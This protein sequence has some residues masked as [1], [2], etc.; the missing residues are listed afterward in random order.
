MG[1]KNFFP[2]ILMILIIT[3]SLAS[4]IIVAA[5]EP[6]GTVVVEKK[7]ITVTIP[8]GGHYAVF[9]YPDKGVFMETPIAKPHLP[10][11]AYEALSKV[12]DWIKPILERQFYELMR[13]DLVAS[14]N[15][16]VSASDFNGDG[17]VDLAVGGSNG[18]ISFYVNV[19]SGLEA[20]FKPYDRI[21]VSNKTNVAPVL[22]DMDGD[23]LVDIVVGLGDGSVVFY[24]NTGTIDSPVWSIDFN[25]FEGVAVGGYA[26]PF[27][28]DADGDGDL[29]LAVGSSEGL[30]YCFINNG[31]PASPS[32]I[33]DPQYFPAWIEDWWDGRGPH[34]E[35]VWVGNYS[36]PALATIGGTT[37]LFIGTNGSSIHVFKATGL[38]DGYPTWSNIGVLPDIELPGARPYLVDL[39]GDGLLDL[40]IGCSDGRVYLVLNKGSPD[41]MLFKVWESGAEEMLLA[42]WFWGPAYYPAIESLT[43]VETTMK[44]VDYYAEIILNTSEPYVDEVAYT[45]A[46]DRPSNLRMLADKDAGYLY[47]LNAESIYDMASKVPYAEISEKEDYST[48]K[49]KT[50]SGWLETP[51]EVYYKY[52]VM[53]N[54]YIIAP[55][56][57]P[58]TYNGCFYRT[59]LPYD[60]TYNVSLFERVSNASTLYEAAYLVDYWLRADIQSWWH[61]GPK[62]R[63]WYNI[64]F[65]LTDPNAGIWC[66]E[67][68]IIYEVAARAM[69]IPTIN[70][71]DIAEDHQFNNFWYNDSWHH[72]DASS[73]SSGVNGTW[74]NYFDPPRGYHDSWFQGTYPMEWEEDGMYDV[75]W[76]SKVPYNPPDKL[77]NLHF[78]VTDLNGKP[79]DGARVEVWSHWTIESGYDTAPYI[80]GF[81]F[82]DMNGECTLPNVGLSRTNNFTIIVTSR[83]GSTMFEAHIEEAGDYYFNVTI[84]GELPPV[85]GPV[86]VVE[87][88]EVSSKYISLNVSV[89]GGEQN[90][91]SWI[92][93]LYAYFDYKYYYVLSGGV[94]AD[95]YVLTGS[96]FTEFLS[97]KPFEA[98]A[99]FED[100]DSASVKFIPV[101]S[102]PLVIVVSNRDSVTTTITV[103]ISV[104]LL[105]DVE[106]PTTIITSPVSG[107]VF[108]T[109][110]VTV[111]FTSSSPD[112]AYFEVSIDGGEFFKAYPP[113]VLEDLSDGIHEVEVRGVDVSGNVGEAVAVVFTVD[114]TPPIIVLETVADG[115]FLTSSNIT[116]EG[117]VVDGV[118]LWF[119]G[120]E[121]PVEADGSFKIVV[122]LVE[123]A[124]VMVFEAADSAGNKAVKRATVVYRPELAT[125]QDL[126]ALQQRVEGISVN[127]NSTLEDVMN[128]VSEVSSEMSGTASNLLSK[129]EDLSLNMRYMQ[130]MVGAIIAILALVAIIGVFI[131]VSKK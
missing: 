15:S 63:G 12:P 11:K 49:Y 17:L 93:V 118:K 54:R 14:G 43:T 113:L 115:M 98:I 61:P 21:T 128:K 1:T 68:S 53:F 20:R 5:E 39:N 32:W 58:D 50:G 46:C 23:G 36:K 73:G 77:A 19:G 125:R 26:V 123:G 117:R 76:R 87:P 119:N 111:N 28:F 85:A 31:T 27:A 92:H 91:P 116:I 37:Y 102:E 84:N 40:L 124:N 86:S 52:L 41:N 70:V 7:E 79:I 106:A 96:R 97:N 71:V 47:Q 112:I 34:Y 75:P 72:V 57:W 89:V 130:D 90:P 10:A 127:V 25:Y 120:V 110:T 121:Y 94:K 101:G 109:T 107:A 2:I 24:R 6:H 129:M 56:R 80:G 51:R 69:L 3:T 64:Y 62:P 16:S 82:T 103:E 99:A 42:N 66:G 131:R 44:Y 45:I 126:E 81:N 95:V 22:A 83:V 8:P 114:T 35:G 122:F 59:F 18:T 4:P 29:D 33:L 78:H 60:K 104:A 30:V 65:H 74:V 48:L 55:W 38:T 13:E 67:F 108:N 105:E 9:F 88:T 100:V